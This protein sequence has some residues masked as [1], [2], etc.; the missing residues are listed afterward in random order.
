MLVALPGSRYQHWPDG[1]GSSAYHCRRVE[2]HP[3]DL[4]GIAHPGRAIDCGLTNETV[5]FWTVAEF[6]TVAPFR[7]PLLAGSGT[8]PTK[9][10][11]GRHTR[12]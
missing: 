1:D 10:G 8:A 4:A 7:L 9:E 2:L 6:H 11:G 5:V 12:A 3:D